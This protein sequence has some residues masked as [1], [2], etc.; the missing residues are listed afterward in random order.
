MISMLVDISVMSDH[1]AYW[2][3][4]SK[5]HFETGNWQEAIDELGKAKELQTKIIAAPLSEGINVPEQRRHASKFVC[6]FKYVS[7]T[8]SAAA[9]R[10]S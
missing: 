7:C 9:V 6:F 5:L 10:F 2:M 8:Q 3:Q 4:L 1:V